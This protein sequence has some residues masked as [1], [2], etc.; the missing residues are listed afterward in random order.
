MFPRYLPGE[1]AIVETDTPPALGEEVF[2]RL[3]DGAMAVAR[4]VAVEENRVLLASVNN[5]KLRAYVQQADID[6]AE[7]IEGRISPPP[8]PESRSTLSGEHARPTL[9]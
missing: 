6:T 4:L 1:V 9:H 3:Y 5:P 8:A 7:R 2:L